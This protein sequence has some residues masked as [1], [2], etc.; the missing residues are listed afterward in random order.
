MNNSQ[1]TDRELDEAWR[2][3]HAT[4]LERQSRALESIRT[5]VSWLLWITV[6]LI[7]LQLFGVAAAMS[8]L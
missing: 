1:F 7:L 2:T 6:T 5:N 4:H 8:Q 3:L